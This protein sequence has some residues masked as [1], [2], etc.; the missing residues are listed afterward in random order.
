MLDCI[1]LKS[2]NG[3][4]P[5]LPHRV[6]DVNDEGF[7]MRLLFKPREGA[8]WGFNQFDVDKR[9]AYQQ[10]LQMQRGESINNL[11]LLQ[12][13]LVVDDYNDYQ[14]PRNMAN[15]PNTLLR[16]LQHQSQSEDLD[17]VTI[18]YDINHRQNTSKKGGFPW[19]FQ[20]MSQKEVN[21]ELDY[22]NN[23]ELKDTMWRVLRC[24]PPLNDILK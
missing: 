5:K 10:Q 9:F 14:D 6:G 2:E 16:N 1:Y 8:L 22:E 24:K 12:S 21:E 23:V 18:N 19:P 13:D 3:K 15:L 20:Q 4:Y 11:S 17:N 7:C